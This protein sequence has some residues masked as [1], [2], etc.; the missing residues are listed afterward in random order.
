[1]GYIAI[2]IIFASMFSV[3][4]VEKYVQGQCVISY[5]QSNKTADEIKRI[6]RG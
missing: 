5:A 2:S 6:C 1:M 4:G 3:I